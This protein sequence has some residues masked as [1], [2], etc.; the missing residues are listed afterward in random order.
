M[1]LNKIGVVLFNHAELLDFAGP[2]QVFAAYH[3]LFEDSTNELITIGLTDEIKVSKIGMRIIPDTVIGAIPKHSHFD[4]IIIPGGFGTREMVKE[5]QSLEAVNH[6]LAQS[7][8]VASVCTGSL[9]LAK[10]GILSGLKATTHF[11]AIDLLK[12]LDPTIEIDRSKRFYDH[13]KIIVAEGVSAGIDM[14]LHLLSKHC[15]EEVSKKVK[16]YIEYY[17][18]KP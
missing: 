16:Q 18:E 13:E 11:A 17:P 12:K 14:S 3:A 15:G 9:V 2:I 1:N 7:V 6:L 5:E 4:L 8:R 10:L